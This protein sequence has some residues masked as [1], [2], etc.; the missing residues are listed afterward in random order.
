MTLGLPPLLDCDCCILASG[1]MRGNAEY[2]ADASLSYGVLKKRAAVRSRSHRSQDA[3]C[4]PRRC[5]TVLEVCG[6]SWNGWLPASRSRRRRWRRAGADARDSILLL[7]STYYYSSCR[8]L[9]NYEIRNLPRLSSQNTPP[10]PSF[11]Y[12]L[13]VSIDHAQLENIFAIS[14]SRCTPLVHSVFLG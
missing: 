5:D 13:R 4:D 1:F 11:P 7:H 12:K 3:R 9:G 6:S 2:S 14:Q 10:S 8:P